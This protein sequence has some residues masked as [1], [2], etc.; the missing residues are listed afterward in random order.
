MKNNLSTTDLDRL[1]E[2]MT[3]LSNAKKSKKESEVIKDKIMDFMEQN[4]IK[5]FRHNGI[6]IRFT[7]SRSTFEFDVQ[8][9]KSK[10]PKIWEE[11]HSNQM[12]PPHLLIKK[13]TVENED[14]EPTDEELN[15]AIG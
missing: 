7:P 11:C 5:T 6:L 10:Y 14:D 9:L 1:E 3:E 4:N 12:R 2:L 15:E 8:L 13:T